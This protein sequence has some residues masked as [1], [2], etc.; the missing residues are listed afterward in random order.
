MRRHGLG[1]HRRV[2]GR[3][4]DAGEVVETGERNEHRDRQRHQPAD[5]ERE[6]QTDAR[7]QQDGLR[8]SPAVRHGA[9]DDAAGDIRHVGERG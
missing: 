4:G 6:Q 2:R 5:G 1:E 9:A 7:P 8:A 3:I